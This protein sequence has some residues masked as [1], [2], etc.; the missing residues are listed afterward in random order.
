MATEVTVTKEQEFYSWNT[1]PYTWDGASFDTWAE[2]AKQYTLL[3]CKETMLIVPLKTIQAEKSLEESVIRL[4][5]RHN[6]TFVLHHTDK[7]MCTEILARTT[8]TIRNILEECFLSSKPSMLTE[9]PFSENLMIYQEQLEKKIDMNLFERLVVEELLRRTADYRKSI[10][11]AAALTDSNKA[12]KDIYVNK[13][14]LARLWDAMLQNC[15][16]VLSDISITHGSMTLKDFEKQLITAPG[17]TPFQD[18]KVGEYEYQKAL[19][20]LGLESTIEHSQPSVSGVIMHVDIPD[21]NDRGN[22]EITD[23]AAPTKVYFN[24]HYY[25][26]PEVKVNLQG[27]NTGVGVVIPHIVSTDKADIDGRYFEVELLNSTGGRV[28]GFITWQSIGY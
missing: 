18:F 16:G 7:I 5:E 13:S 22:V 15:R 4:S 6:K 2:A 14:E 17:Y 25:K 20:R 11:E 21:T 19:I 9:K 27:G 12:I 28:T 1:A 8:E 23:T 10:Q 24:K 26:P 3:D